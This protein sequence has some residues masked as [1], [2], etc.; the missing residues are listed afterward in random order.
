MSDAAPESPSQQAVIRRRPGLTATSRAATATAWF[1]GAVAVAALLGLLATG[2]AEEP[3]HLRAAV[4]LAAVPAT[5]ADR[6][7][8]TLAPAA[9]AAA[10]PTGPLVLA[11]EFESR[12]GQTYIAALRY[13]QAPEALGPTLFGGP[14]GP[15][16][17]P[18][19]GALAGGRAAGRLEVQLTATTSRTRLEARLPRGA[20]DAGASSQAAPDADAAR[21]LEL[22]VTERPDPWSRG[23]T[24]LPGSPG[25]E[26]VL[27][28]L[29]LYR[30]VRPGWVLRPG[31]EL[32]LPEPL[33]AGATRLRLELA[34]ARHLLRRPTEAGDDEL[35]LRAVR[36]DGF[37]VDLGRARPRSE[38]PLW[39]PLDVALTDF[40]LGA[41]ARLHLSVA[42]VAPGGAGAGGISGADG[43]DAGLAVS[44]PVAL[45]ERGVRRPNLVL[46]SIDTLR[47]DRCGLYGYPRD[48]TPHLDALAERALV[49]DDALSTAPYTLPSHASMLSGQYPSRHG[50]Q[51]TVHAVHPERTPLLAER[52]AAAGWDTRAA[53][54]G[55]YLDADYGLARGFGAYGQVDPVSGAGMLAGRTRQPEAALQLVGAQDWTAAL[56]WMADRRDV[57]FFLFLQTFAVHDYQPP[58]AWRARF[59]EHAHV[60][61]APLRK[62][63]EQLRRPYTDDELAALG[64]RYD[65]GLAWVDAQVGA[66]LR[67][68]DDL[69]LTGHT[70]VVVTSDHGEAF[71][72]RGLNGHG[73]SLHAEQLRVPL[74]LGLPGVPARRLMPRVSLVD[75]TPTLLD[76]LGLE[77]GDEVDG[78]SLRPLW[79][80]PQADFRPSPALAEVDS[81]VAR[82]R[83]LYDGPAKLILAEPE[84]AVELPALFAREFYD[85]VEDPAETHELLAAGDARAA[86]APELEHA[87]RDL[88]EALAAQADGAPASA[89]LDDDTRQRLV[90]LGYLDAGDGR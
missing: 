29:E 82:A 53:T 27:S 59:D 18:V 43:S 28:T 55:G 50:A 33:P 12:P 38:L 19:L 22:V 61:V 66:L 47:R 24:G 67:R 5:V 90:E 83:A 31:D 51:N 65:A 84:A 17:L 4:R 78:R 80:A 8:L 39:E 69:D 48:T 35:V 32:L 73:H 7:V 23:P 87:L 36:A 56:D 2:C 21:L 6:T 89:T 10:A 25:H 26:P 77:T 54:G 68:L 85:V 58:D 11:G 86:R 1:A 79:E 76:L 40:A 70:L 13:E 49:F 44:G 20:P 3:W 41:G 46:I 52:L 72:E 34:P 64:D 60:E 42:S 45:V 81:N 74:L 63:P 71:G 9:D 16:E 14:A 88:A 75:L 37:S 15:D 30:D 62:L 57:P